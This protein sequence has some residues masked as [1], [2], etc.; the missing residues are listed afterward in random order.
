VQHRRP[1]INADDRPATPCFVG[2]GFLGPGVVTPGFL[3]PCFVGSG[4]PGFL[5]PGDNSLA[6]EPH[7]SAGGPVGGEYRSG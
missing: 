1:G 6:N 5:A 7:P 4:G 2:S 3:T